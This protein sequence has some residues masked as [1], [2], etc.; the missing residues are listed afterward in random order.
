MLL[1]MALFYS[2]Y[3]LS[4][5]P[6]C[7]CVCV[8]VC[9]SPAP[10]YPF[11]HSSVD[12]Q[13]LGS[14]HVL[15]IVNSAAMNIGV[16][17][18]FQISFVWVYAQEWDC[19]IIWQLYFQFFKEPPYCS[20]QWLHQFTFPQTVWQGSSFSTPSLAFI[21]C[22]LLDDGHSGQCEVVPHCSFDLHKDDIGHLAFIICRLLDDGHSGQCEVV[23]HCS[24]DLHKD[25]IKFLWCDNSIRILRGKSNVF[26]CGL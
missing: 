7:V 24:F 5:I 23:P 16:H 20:P 8:C 10:P 4:S 14:F 2:F 17:V 3:W 26:V 25:D 6:L 22:R 18:T 19:W 11:V 9:V 12:R 21:I 1:Q 13:H 15:A